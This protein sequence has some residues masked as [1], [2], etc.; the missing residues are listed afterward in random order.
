MVLYCTFVVA[1]QL[2][3]WLVS[4]YL[5]YSTTAFV[6]AAAAAAASSVGDNVILFYFIFGSP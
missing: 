1:L 4:S 6:A 3:S 5:Q 2:V